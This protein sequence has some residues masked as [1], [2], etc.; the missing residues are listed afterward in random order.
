VFAALAGV[1]LEGCGVETPRGCTPVPIYDWDPRAPGP[2]DDAILNAT[3]Q[4]SIARVIGEVEIEPG[5]REIIREQDN[6]LGTIV[7]HEG[8]DWIIYTHNHYTM[9]G[10]ASD[11]TQVAIIRSWDGSREVQ[12]G[13]DEFKPE[14]SGDLIKLRVPASKLDGSGLSTEGDGTAPPPPRI[15]APIQKTDGALVNI[16]DRIDA[17]WWP[18]EGD[19]GGAP[20]SIW[21]SKVA[22]REG[23]YIHISGAVP[24][25]GL[26]EIGGRG[27]SGGGVF[28]E[29]KHIANHKNWVK[30]EIQTESGLP[31]CINDAYWISYLNP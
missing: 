4:I 2:H 9:L 26:V 22:A 17:V 23:R 19:G 30:V 12:L 24:E 14:P 1:A 11:P 10:P 6:S 27:D 18:P 29:G 8:E 3:V 28:Y 15:G 20:V 21:H 25:G 16:D 31:I 13:M 5:V 7:G